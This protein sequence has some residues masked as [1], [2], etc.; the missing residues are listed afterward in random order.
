[1]SNLTDNS[2]SH[3]NEMQRDAVFTTD[4]PVL[5]FAG[6]G[7]GKTTVLVN[8]IA[9][10]IESG[11][12]Q[13]YHILAITFTNKA[14]NELKS[15]IVAMLGTPGED[16]WASTF[17]STCVRILRRY[18]DRLGYEKSFNIFDRGDQLSIV[19]ECLKTLRLNDTNYPPKVVLSIIGKA[20]DYLQT[21][22]EFE[23]I[24][25]SDYRMSQIAKIYTLYQKRLR[26]CNAL[27]FDDIIV[28]A[29][30]LLEQ[31]DEA[32]AYYQNKF[33]YI[34][35][36]E[37]QDTNHAQYRLVSLLSSGSGN[38]CVVGD[39]DQS[40]Y[41]FRG[42]DIENILS[43]EKEYKNAK[44]IKLEQ[45]YRSTQTILDAANHV[46]KNNEGRTGKN[47]WTDQGEGEIIALYEAH[48]EHDEG[49]FI[50]EKIEELHID[51]NINY[52]NFALLY[53][54]NAQSRVLEEM[55]I[56]AAIPYKV[57]SGTRFYDRKEI[58][59][60]VAFL[61]TIY[62]YDDDVSL[63]RIINEP[64]RSIGKA[65]VELVQE[66]ADQNGVSMFRLISSVASV[67][68]LQKVAVKLSSFAA[69]IMSLRSKMDTPDIAAFVKTV[70]EETGYL[71]M[72]EME[73]GIEKIARLEN[74]GEF[75][76]VAQEYQRGVEDEPTLGGFLESVALYSDLDDYDEEQDNVFLMTLHS[77]K[78]LEFPVV[79]LPGLEEGLFPSFLSLDD[80]QQ[81]EEERR[82]CYVG[83]TRA[84]KRL[85]ISYAK[86]R[87]QYGK[88]AYCRPS[89]FIK[90][91]PMQ[92]F[93]CQ[94]AA[95]RKATVA[96]QYQTQKQ[97]SD[98]GFKI[99]TAN[100]SSNIAADYK[101]GERVKHKKF[102]VGIILN[103][104]SV[105]SDQRLEIA[106]DDVGTKNLMA[107][108]ASLNKVG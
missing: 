101:I 50:A 59:D 106:F 43:F 36:D 45:N 70:M 103:V 102:G 80:K 56:K 5:I 15:R 17:H 72:I 38:I 22:A 33:K 85:Y 88:T 82:L 25:Q 104:Q 99:T 84:K 35:V 100:A 93:D 62:N 57:L 4:G 108:Y 13:P 69:L 19:K 64:K 81:L 78:G 44:V 79:F 53:R 2:F 21:P 23:K 83:I 6:A 26:D 91:V 3:L 92:L 12:S 39:D 49:R 75:I 11:L 67:P 107:A 65:T 51:E 28:Q 41:K 48:N 29:V 76:S 52:N 97:T 42:A 24:Y 37:Y 87:S 7:S 47:L 98:F 90:E 60:V 46:I 86:C 77:A 32:L 20:K 105:G 16:V 1:M 94:Y 10:I 73:E 95:P 66:I 8:R 54:T 96:N 63:K 71:N 14:A 34:M 68:Q 61:R 31:D 55:L 30:R 40:I 89:R 9:H 74:L 18:I 27:D 58:K